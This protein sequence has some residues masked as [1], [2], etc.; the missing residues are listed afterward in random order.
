MHIQAQTGDQVVVEVT[1]TVDVQMQEELVQLAK[2]MQEVTVFMLHQ[3][4][5]LVEEEE[6]VRLGQTVQAQYQV[7]VE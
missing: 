3:T 4:T 5:E 2:A 7:T 6:Q 1:L